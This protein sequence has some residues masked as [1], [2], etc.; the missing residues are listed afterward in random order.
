MSNSVDHPR[1]KDD[2][3]QH[4]D[5]VTDGCFS[6]PVRHRLAGLRRQRSG[7]AGRV[8][9]AAVSRQASCGGI[10]TPAIIE[11]LAEVRERLASD[12]RSDSQEEPASRPGDLVERFFIVSPEGMEVSPK[13]PRR[14][15]TLRSARVS[16]RHCGKAD[17]PL[18]S[19]RRHRPRTLR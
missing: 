7:A 19:F 14:T 11:G 12:S 4:R 1:R 18:H 16:V 10:S 8:D 13:I 15:P 5:R 6:G 2:R 3:R 9:S 17:Q